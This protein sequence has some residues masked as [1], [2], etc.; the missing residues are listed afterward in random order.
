M[1]MY[2]SSCLFVVFLLSVLRV[3]SM[4]CALFFYKNEETNRGI[5]INSTEKENKNEKKSWEDG[6]NNDTNF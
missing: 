4:T 6:F 1:Y 3:F 5:K 2:S